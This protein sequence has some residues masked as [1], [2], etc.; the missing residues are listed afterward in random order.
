MASLHRESWAENIW[1]CNKN[2]WI[3]P[4]CS[5]RLFFQLVI[6]LSVALHYINGSFPFYIEHSLLACVQC[7]ISTYSE[8]HMFAVSSSILC[9][10]LPNS[11]MCN[12]ND[13]REIIFFFQCSSL[14][15]QVKQV[16]INEEHKTKQNFG[17]RSSKLGL[18]PE[19]NFHCWFICLLIV[20]VTIRLRWNMFVCRIPAGGGCGIFQYNYFI[21]LFFFFLYSGV[22]HTAF[23]L[24][25]L[26]W[27]L[28]RTGFMPFRFQ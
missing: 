6:L 16:K 5:F 10:A 1:R 2:R 25:I 26:C 12:N 13:Q 22:Q 23:A 24:E 7:D 18:S 11:E 15:E 3:L 19:L 8:V 20:L 9:K 28:R 17:K 27:S 21:L 14:S 4:V